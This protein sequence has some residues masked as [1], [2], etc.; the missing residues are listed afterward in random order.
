[1]QAYTGSTFGTSACGSEELIWMCLRLAIQVQSANELDLFA[2]DEYTAL[3]RYFDY[4][5]PQ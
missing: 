2:Y 5:P 4:N 3:R 1:M